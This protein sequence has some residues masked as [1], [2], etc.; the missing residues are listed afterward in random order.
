[1]ENTLLTQTI[2]ARIPKGNSLSQE[3]IDW[4]NALSVK[5]WMP[6]PVT[7]PTSKVTNRQIVKAVKAYLA[8]GGTIPA[9]VRKAFRDALVIDD[10]DNPLPD[11]V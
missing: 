2:L 8:D 3:A 9:S 6:D 1:M 5:V 7:M 4:L 11:T 10:S